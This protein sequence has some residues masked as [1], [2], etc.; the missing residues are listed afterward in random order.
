MDLR[1]LVLSAEA[2]LADLVRAQV[3]N[4][5]CRCTVATSYDEASA[6]IGWAD[7]AIVDLA[8]DGIDDLNRLRVEAPTIR[9]L[10][11]TPDADKAESARSSGVDLVLIE[12]F[13]ISDLVQAVRA[14]GRAGNDT[15][16]DLDAAGASPK[17]ADDA[18]WWATR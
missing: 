1:V 7:A 2:E 9:T 15:T 12:P 18:P 14:I 13:A 3:E 16:V 4:L 5:G 8:G 17:P 10:A 6:A 11:I